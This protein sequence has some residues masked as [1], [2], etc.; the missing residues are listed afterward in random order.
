[1]AVD[2]ATEWAVNVQP[3][4]DFVLEPRRWWMESANAQRSLA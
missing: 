2:F 3:K 4:I 1:M